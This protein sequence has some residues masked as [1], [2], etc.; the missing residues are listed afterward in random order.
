MTL[1]NKIPVLLMFPVGAI[2][3]YF[4]GANVHD[5]PSQMVHG[6]RQWLL[7]LL[8]VYAINFSVAWF[9]KNS[10]PA[11][12]GRMLVCGLFAYI[13]ISE[14]VDLLGNYWGHWGQLLGGEG[15]LDI[16]TVHAARYAGTAW[17]VGLV[18]MVLC[19]AVG[20]E[21]RETE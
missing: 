14:L 16:S 9:L 5:V 19:V 21:D 3:I 13:A 4:L 1:A 20:F 7:I 11:A 8:G 12:L 10:W 2:A 18:M 17:L 6:A 15:R